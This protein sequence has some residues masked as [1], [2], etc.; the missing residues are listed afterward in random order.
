MGVDPG[1]VRVGIAL[2]DE[3]GITARPHA[4]LERR[5]A[6]AAAEAIR[7]L[8]AE[9]GVE[10]IVVGLPLRMDGGEQA[11][12]ADARDLASAIERATGRPVVLWDERL[13]TAQAERALVEGNVRRKDRRRVVDRVAATLLLQSYLD[14][15][16]AERP[17][18]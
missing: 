12:T 11:S 14:S 16:A 18:S 5:T 8:A 4:T 2:S 13:T 10:R 6:A 7:A 1:T 15:A 3:L 17:G 9:H